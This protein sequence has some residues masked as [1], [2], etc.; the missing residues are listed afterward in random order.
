MEKEADRPRRRRR[1]GVE[2][3][4][5]TSRCVTKW[6]EPN[7]PCLKATELGHGEPSGPSRTPGPRQARAAAG[8]EHSAHLPGADGTPHLQ[9]LH[10]VQRRPARPLPLSNDALLDA[11]V[12]RARARGAR[13][14]ALQAQ[15]PSSRPNLRPC[16]QKP[17][18]SHPAHGGQVVLHAHMHA[19]PCR[20]YAVRQG[21]RTD[22]LHTESTRGAGPCPQGRHALHGAGVCQC[23]NAPLCQCSHFPMPL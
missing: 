23:T 6:R 10:K 9:P 1:G 16:R 19:T 12:R 11:A 7:R 3:T 2:G 4:G 5:P 14:V 15:A 13:Q 18:R 8:Q 20:S 22:L 21:V 17:E